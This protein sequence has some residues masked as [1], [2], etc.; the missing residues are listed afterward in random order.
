MIGLDQVDDYE[1]EVQKEV[2][3]VGI[4][5]KLEWESATG[6]LFKHNQNKFFDKKNNWEDQDMIGPMS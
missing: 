3:P 5:A 1:E 6:K 4:R 2:A